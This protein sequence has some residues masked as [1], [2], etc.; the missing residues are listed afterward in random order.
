MRKGGAAARRKSAYDAAIQRVADLTLQV[1]R[2][3]RARAET[4]ELRE[5]EVRKHVDDLKAELGDVRR[6][7]Q[8]RAGTVVPASSGNRPDAGEDRTGRR[9][10]RGPARR[11]RRGAYGRRGS[12]RTCHG[13]RGKGVGRD[14]GAD[15]RLSRTRAAMRRNSPRWRRVSAASWAPFGG[16]PTTISRWSRSGRPLPQRSGSWFKEP[17]QLNRSTARPRLTS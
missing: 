11:S 13:G 10:C 4:A 17:C 5:V 14:Q 16:R 1:A 9:R 15:G 2:C 12:D 8:G 3:R 6:S 7:A